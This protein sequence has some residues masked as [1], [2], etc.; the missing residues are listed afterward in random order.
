MTA[1]RRPFASPH[2]VALTITMACSAA[3]C[4][5]TTYEGGAAD[6]LA[7]S[8]P[9]VATPATE[10]IS[11]NAA[12]LLPHLAAD[13]SGLA[14]VMIDGGDD[15][16]SAERIAAL[17]AA[18]SQEVAASRPE[19]LADFEANVR[20]CAS[21]VEFNRAADADKAAANLRALVDAYLG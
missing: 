4:A 15:R 11:G 7:T 17:W 3:A 5:S 19:L 18:A 13:A 20:R 21:A 9:A 12:D 8:S 1:R 6:T 2:L 16:A 10:A 14:R